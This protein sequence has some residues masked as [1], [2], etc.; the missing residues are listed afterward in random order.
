MKVHIMTDLEAVAGV[1]SQIDYCIPPGPNKY[2]LT[3][4]GKYY[5]RAREMITLEVNAAI[6]GLL[7]GGATQI[8]VCDGHGFGSIDVSRI[9]CAARVLSGTGLTYPMGLDDSI[10]ATIMVGQHAMGNTDGGHLCHSGSFSREE[11]RLNGQ[12]IGEIHLWALLAQYFEVP[13][14]MLSGDRAG[15]EEVRSII[16]S[17]LTVQVIEGLKRGSTAGMTAL[18][19]LVHNVPAI[20]VSP[21]RSREMIREGAATCLA[22]RDTVERYWVLPPYEVVRVQRRSESGPGKRAVNR[23]DD[24]IDALTQPTRYE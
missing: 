11:W 14:V 13:L 12:L 6:E 2:G 24:L 21:Q 5:E 16:P 23:S 15:C 4:T 17:I 20:H 18:E 10:D 8:L 1:V 22:R 19:A 9:H 7:E 3:G